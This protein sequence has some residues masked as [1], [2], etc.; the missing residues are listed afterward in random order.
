LFKF[1]LYKIFTL[2]IDSPVYKY[3]ELAKEQ[4]STKSTSFHCK[5]CLEKGIKDKEGSSPVLRKYGI[6]TSNLI[7][8][9]HSKGHEHILDELEQIKK[10]NST[11]KR[12]LNFDEDKENGNNLLNM[13]AIK[14]VQKY[15]MQSSIQK[16]R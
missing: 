8:H 1:W 11:K 13:G 14:K 9:L 12:K 6:S 10:N 3:F 5:L 7:S 15:S 2:T 16:D 4:N